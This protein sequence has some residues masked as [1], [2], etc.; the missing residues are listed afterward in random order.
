MRPSQP[1]SRAN[2]RRVLA[3][4]LAIAFVT[5]FGET[6]VLPLILPNRPGGWVD[7]SLDAFVL[8]L[9]LAPALWWLLI[10]PLRREHEEAEARFRDLVESSPDGI[11][12]V[13]RS[14]SIRLANGRAETLFGYP[15][16]ELVGRPVEVLVPGMS[17]APH[18]AD[19]AA[20]QQQ[21]QLRSMGRGRDLRAL[22]KDGT[23]FPV[24]VNL[25]PVP[26]EGELVIA[27]VRDLTERREAERAL[28]ESER[29]YGLVVQNIDEIVYAVE[30]TGDPSAERVLFMSDRVGSVTGHQPQEFMANPQLWTSLIHPDDVSAVMSLTGRLLTER[31]P[32]TRLYRLRDDRTGQYL[33]IEDR[34]APY[35][36]RTD[37]RVTL[38][39]VARDVTERQRAQ[40][41]LAEQSK[42]LESFFKHTQTG[43]VFL[44]RD[45]DIIRV[46]D[47]Y[48]K[49]CQRDVSEFAGRNHFEL[50]PSAAR[51]ECERVVRTRESF[52]AIARPFTFPDHPDWDVTYWDLMLVPILDDRGDVEFLVL[53][54]NDVTERKRAE[55]AL[56]EAEQ[57]LRTV[58][59][60]APIAIFA[61]DGNGVFTLS[62]GKGLQRV[63]LQPGE[64]VGTSALELYSSLPV[65]DETGA[66]TTGAAVVHRVLAGETLTGTTELRGVYFD[67]HFVPLRDPYGQVIGMVGVAFDTTDRKRAEIALRDSEERL[68]IV[69]DNMQDLVSQI[70]LDGTYVYVSPSHH[71]VLGYPPQSLLGTSAFELVHPDDLERVRTVVAEAVQRHVSGRSDFR[72]R[73]ADGHFV[74]LEAVGTLL[75]DETGTPRGAVLSAH[76]ITKR[77]SANDALRDAHTRLQSLSRRLLTIQETERRSLARELHDEIGQALTATK[78]N[79][80]AFER[81]SDPASLALRLQDAN[82]MVDGALEQVRSLSLELRPPLLDDLGLPAAL[83]WLLDQHARRS[84]L[85]VQ[86]ASDAFEGRLATEIETACFRIA[87]QGLT[88]VVKHAGARTVTVRLRR[89]G[90]ALHLHVRDDGAGFDVPAAR[91]RAMHGESLGLVGMEERAALAGGGIEW[92]SAPGLGTDVHAWFALAPETTP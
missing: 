19:R 40:Q 68:R 63:G 89:V 83:R 69:T 53:S 81:I 84:G 5:A 11:L 18:A 35:V 32:V 10:Q 54:V 76:D 71:K 57:W 22:R 55:E 38:V 16:T 65:L 87:Q 3:V 24:D 23:E 58:V 86:Y 85:G 8:V 92:T 7:A 15:R 37:R 33:W 73:H 52:Q 30:T 34:V 45:F 72:C 1:F 56:R 79:L 77:K 78:I 82:S 6:F 12:A 17:R 48:A 46:N 36:A 31:V 25:S 26:R 29:R 41:L 67:N 88:N 28:R 90:D 9:I 27:I 91:A 74:W 4:P 44:D 39:G 50:Y 59:S 60:N 64:N 75:L 49:A 80:Q 66:V 42:I 70:G 47:A 62:E 20:F 21:P 51:A 61:T 43:L 2:A 13:D 14:G